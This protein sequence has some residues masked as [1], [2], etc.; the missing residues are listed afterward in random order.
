MHYFDRTLNVFG[1]S[2]AYLL[3]GQK[4]PFFIILNYYFHPNPPPPSKK[5]NK[6]KQ[7]MNTDFKAVL[8]DPS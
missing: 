2:E 7:K 5:K 3:S 4:P 6:T 1:F 8:T